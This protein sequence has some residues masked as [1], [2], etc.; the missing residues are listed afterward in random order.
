MADPLSIAASIAGVISLADVV[1]S[2][3]TKYVSAVKHADE[4]VKKF[5]LE[6]NLLGGALSSLSK[7]AS[8]LDADGLRNKQIDDLRMHHISTCHSTLHQIVQ[9][10]EKLEDKPLKR[11]VT[12]PFTS[13]RTKESLSEVSRH[14]E[15]INL[16]LTATSMDT[17]LRNLSK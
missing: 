11:K 3:T 12:W 13:E 10:L 14:K 15:T 4:E 5:A 8:V 9:N 7:L 17:L 16:A 2:R 1:F 6:V